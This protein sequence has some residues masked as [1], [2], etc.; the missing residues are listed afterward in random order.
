V[1]P[2]PAQRRWRD[3]LDATEQELPRGDVTE[4]VVRVGPTV[5]RPHHPQSIAIAHYLDHLE[6]TGFDGSPRYLGRDDQGRDV[7]SFIEGDVAAASP[8]RWA[9]DEG[10]LV[11]VAILVVRLLEAG[12]GFDVPP[13]L[14]LPRPGHPADT[15]V[16]HLDVTPQNV[17]TRD[18]RAI[19][20]IDFDLARRASRYDQA[21]NA[22]LHWV[23]LRDPADV[24]PEWSGIDQPRRLRLLADAFGWS[25][26]DRDDFVPYALEHADATWHRMKQRAETDGGGWA[27][28]WAEGVGDQIRRRRQWVEREQATL[29]AA[30]LD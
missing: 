1:P 18:G 21:F 19:A 25:R 30:L 11:S 7:L 4:G 28:M 5:R 14:F 24:Y 17:V 20:L 13:S 16:T 23:P 15:V 26:G 10:L 2:P 3:V 27:R 29:H 6:R 12:G 22:A 8:E 9:A